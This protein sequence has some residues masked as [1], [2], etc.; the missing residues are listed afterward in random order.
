VVS[1]RG[2]IRLRVSLSVRTRLVLSIQRSNLRLPQ[3]LSVHD[4]AVRRREPALVRHT[5]FAGLRHEMTNDLTWPHRTLTSPNHIAPVSA[6]SCS[7]TGKAKGLTVVPVLVQ[8]NGTYLIKSRNNS[9]RTCSLADRPQAS[10]TIA[11][12]EGQ[13]GTEFS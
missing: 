7:R 12:M 2:R 4:N 5:Q 1:K 3:N 10:P 6:L 11:S 8:P 9:T 13:H